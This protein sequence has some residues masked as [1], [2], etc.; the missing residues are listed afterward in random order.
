MIAT[1]QSEPRQSWSGF[2]ARLHAL[3]ASAAPVVLVFRRGPA[4]SVCLILWNRE[5]DEALRAPLRYLAGR[6]T[7][8]LG[9]AKRLID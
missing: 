5:P 2:P 7:H 1:K 3:L 9:A 8:G 6:A 4:N